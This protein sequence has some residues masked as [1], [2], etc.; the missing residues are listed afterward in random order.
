MKR[1]TAK[2]LI[3]RVTALGVFALLVFVIALGNTNSAYANEDTNQSSNSQ[4][5]MSEDNKGARV[6]DAPFSLSNFNRAQKGSNREINGKYYGYS[7][8]IGQQTNKFIQIIATEDTAIVYIP[9]DEADSRSININDKETQ[10]ILQ[11]CLNA[12]DAKNNTGGNNLEKIGNIIYTSDTKVELG[13]VDYLFDQKIGDDVYAFVIGSNGEDV[14]DS[15]SANYTKPVFLDSASL[16]TYDDITIGKEKTWIDNTRDFLAN[17]DWSPLYVT[18]KTTGVAIVV[19]FILGLLAAYFALS[20]SGKTRSILDSLFTIPMV[21]PP[22]V[23]GF[24][25][26]FLC[27]SNTGFGRFFINIGFPLIFSW[28][29]TVIAAVV[30]SFP[31]MYRSA[32]GAFEN[33]DANLLNSA[34][35]LGWSNA[36]IFRK[37]MMPLSWSSIAAGTVL[38]FTRALGEFGAT[39]FLA[40]NYVGITR[41]IPIAIYFEWMNGNNETAWFWT[42]IVIAVSF[43]VILFINIWSNRT[44]KYRRTK[45]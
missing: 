36:K 9:K 18:I 10:G 25:L 45:D 8:L 14:T 2:T 1:I 41:T 39:L 26:L 29:A 24:I 23:C 33:L 6:I 35:T 42:A 3:V 17:L 12:L 11:T 7:Y 43:L 20:L 40:G 31:L 28:P 13:G 38:A 44:V 16:G 19:V 34:K 27:G 37:L 32:L 5:Q 21:L 30:V 15:E 22:T 4:I